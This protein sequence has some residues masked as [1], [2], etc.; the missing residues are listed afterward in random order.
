[1]SDEY[2]KE[3]RV[4]KEEKEIN[5]FDEV[6]SGE[7]IEADTEVSDMSAIGK[8]INI[9]LSPTIAFKAIKAKPT[10]LI[11]MIIVPLF[12]LLY[13]LLF[14]QSYEV[15]MIQMIETQFA[16]MGMEL[17]RELL[18]MQLKLLRITTPIGAAVGVYIG[19]LL[20]TIIYFVIGKIIKTGVTFKQTFS[21][22]IHASII[23]SLIWVVHMLVTLIFGESDIL[24]PMTSLASFLPESMYGTILYGLMIPF[25]VITIWY[26]I[27]L[28]LGLKITC[29]YSKKAAA[30]TVAVTM[31][32]SILLSAS[33]FLMT[34]FASSM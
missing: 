23:S 16:S 13:Y 10:I 9:V 6:V 3:T 33:S 2:G 5:R 29:N 1:M 27:V 32:I 25:E 30:I 7:V 20:S 17:T 34:G 24:A 26:L 4:V 15:Q 11:A 19:V 8:I 14:W 12:S 28:Y 31:L 21:M 22:G 18:E